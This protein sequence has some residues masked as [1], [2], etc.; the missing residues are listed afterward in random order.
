MSSILLGSTNVYGDGVDI[1]SDGLQFYL[2]STNTDSYSGS[3]TA[4]YDLSG[5]GNNFSWASTP[6]F[7]SGS[8]SYFTT[9]SGGQCSG[10]ASNSFGI[11]NTSGYTI[12]LI[13][14]VNSYTNSTAFLFHS[15]TASYNR[16][17]QTHVTWGNQVVYFDQGGCCSSNTRTNVNS[18]G[19]LTW[20]I[21]TFRRLTNSS[22]RSI[23]KNGS[24]LINNTAGAA[25][26]ALSGTAVRINMSSWNARLGGFICYNR[27]L[28]D[29]EIADNYS[30]LR[31][32]YGI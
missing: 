18:G 2:D 23:W 9:T 21:W 1:I 22:T 29:A 16:G 32:R 6:S 11:T 3:G 13:C 24:N 20:I 30:T 27:G 8:P 19:A 4:W 7:T 25:N 15:S 17:I 12:H 31:T 26:P 14:R 10:P 28:S 5:N